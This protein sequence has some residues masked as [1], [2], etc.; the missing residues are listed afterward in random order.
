[1]KTTPHEVVGIQKD[2]DKAQIKARYRE[3]AKRYHPDAKSDNS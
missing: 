1:M 2:A 3:L